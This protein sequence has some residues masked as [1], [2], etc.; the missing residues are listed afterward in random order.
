MWLQF[1]PIKPDHKVDQTRESKSSFSLEEPKSKIL[2]GYCGDQSIPYVQ[3]ALEKAG[4]NIQYLMYRLHKN[5]PG[6]IS[7]PRIR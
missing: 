3:I 2:K 1:D 5:G 7:N 4:P 6:P